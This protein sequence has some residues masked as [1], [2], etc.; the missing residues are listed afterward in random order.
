MINSNILDN[1]SVIIQGKVLGNP[2][3]NYE[4]QLT[5]QCIES[6]RKFIPGAEIIVSTW[7]GS[8]VSH[9]P[10]DKVV[11]NRDPGAIAYSIY[12]PDYLNNNN[13][14][15]VSTYNG[16]TAGTKKFGIKM[17]G[18]CKLL[19]TSF[20][21]NLKEYPRSD[22]YRFFKQRII[23]PTFYSRNP[24]R[25]AQLIH[26]SDV[27]QVGLLEDLQD[28]WNVPLQ[29]EPETTRALPVEKKIINDTLGNSYRRS[30]FGPEQYI[31]YAFSKKNGL[32]MELKHFSDIP[33]SKI[34]PSDWSIINNFVIEESEKLGVLLPPKMTERRDMQKD[35]YTHQE[36]AKLAERYAKGV[37]PA[38]ELALIAQV[39]ASNVKN[40]AIKAK[41]KIFRDASGIFHG[42]KKLSNPLTWKTRQ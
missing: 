29:P 42:I 14:Q 6:I 41:N 19:G 1:F 24:R 32:D 12:E 26:P 10:V 13:R 18:D 40:I 34:L 8:D 7:E 39:Y 33:A 21:H 5:L 3:D 35:L 38:F 15:I 28:L 4:K 22:K 27:F 31:W 30:K 25:I 2:G 36:W 17:R 16:L 37:T 9:L 23:I 11:F 20:I